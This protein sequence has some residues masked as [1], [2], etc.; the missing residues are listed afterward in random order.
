MKIDFKDKNSIWRFKISDERLVNKDT[1]NPKK[2]VQYL[3]NNIDK[4]SSDYI[5]KYDFI[6]YKDYVGF[7]VPMERT[8]FIYRKD[9]VES[10]F[11]NFDNYRVLKIK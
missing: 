5:G 9:Y 6:I 3:I 7:I 11:I 4:A 10:R 8:T 1:K 2:I